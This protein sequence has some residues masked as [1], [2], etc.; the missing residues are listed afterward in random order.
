[1]QVITRRNILNG[2]PQQE[3]RVSAT[4]RYCYKPIRCI[5]FL[6][7]CA[8]DAVTKNNH[9]KK[10]RVTLSQIKYIDNTNLH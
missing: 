6:K 8:L 3:S 4:F 2:W 9:L 1:M 5:I 7:L 10:T